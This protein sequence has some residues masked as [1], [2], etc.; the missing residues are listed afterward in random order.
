M[1]TRLMD[2]EVEDE[3]D[4][5]TESAPAV[6]GGFLDAVD[7]VDEDDNPVETRALPDPSQFRST[8]RPAAGSGAYASAGRKARSGAN[9]RTGPR[10]EPKEAA[11]EMLA[12]PRKH[13][14]V[15]AP[16][17]EPREDPPISRDRRDDFEFDDFDEDGGG[18]DLYGDDDDGFDDGDDG[19]VDDVP[20]PSASEIHARKVDL[21]HKMHRMKDKG[22]VV[23][24]F[25][26]RSNLDEMQFEYDK[27][28]HALE[29]RNAIQTMRQILIAGTS[30][31]QFLNSRY[32]PFGLKL[33]GWSESVMS[34]VADYDNVFERLYEKHK[35]KVSVA[36]EIQLLFMLGGSAMMF[37][38][39]A[40]FANSD[41]PP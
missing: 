30:A 15:F 8:D 38:M 37:H 1:S 31:A 12:N 25:T 41:C 32:D 11:L 28:M 33:D 6:R 36:P 9:A 35:N 2:V 10:A 3:A 22:I 40:S 20:R 4:Y 13:R 18:E 19:Y 21:L 23:G 27:V 7:L 17:P 39:S 14:S 24:D 29:V 26:M 34:N 16:P 5:A